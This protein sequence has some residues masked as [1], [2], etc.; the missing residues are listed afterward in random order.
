M[1]YKSVPPQQTNNTCQ[2]FRPFHR[3]PAVKLVYDF[4][5]HYTSKY[6]IHVKNDKFQNN[7]ESLPVAVISSIFL[8]SFSN[9]F[10]SC[11]FVYFCEG[12]LLYNFLVS[13]FSINN[14]IIINQWIL[15]FGWNILF[16]VYKGQT[17]YKNIQI[18]E[19]NEGDK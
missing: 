17:K 4:F 6:K 16:I 19:I 3:K 5:L 14:R 2:F 9:P 13:V 18:R 1:L 15:F 12:E 8:C 10:R 7:I 11:D